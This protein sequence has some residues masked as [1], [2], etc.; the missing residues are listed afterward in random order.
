MSDTSTA[1]TT[2]AEEQRVDDFYND[3]NTC[4]SSDDGVLFWIDWSRLARATNAQST[5]YDDLVYLLS[6]AI[7]IKRRRAMDGNDPIQTGAPARVVRRF[8]DMIN[9][10]SP[11]YPLGFGLNE[12]KAMYV[13]CERLDVKDNILD[14]VKERF[15]QLSMSQPWS[16]LIWAG[17]RNDVYMAKSTLKNMT[18]AL[19]VSG[20]HG[21]D[22][23]QETL[24]ALPSPWRTNLLQLVCTEGYTKMNKRGRYFSCLAITENWEAVA[25]KFD[26][27]NS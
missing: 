26:P 23:F 13:L 10:S 5:V 7:G 21:E 19:F 18:A 15:N 27:E 17:Q 11:V 16:V 24:N 22:R 4:L 12:T 9:V 2:R 25:N 1:S 14:L 3:G 6:P 20:Q 8:L